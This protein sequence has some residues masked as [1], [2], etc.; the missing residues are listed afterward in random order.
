PMSK[1]KSNRV[2]LHRILKAPVERVFRAFSDPD[3]M[4]YWLPPF[5]FL[6]KVLEQDFKVGG[7]Y[8]MAFINFTDNASH[9]FGGKYVEI[10][11]GEVISYTDSFDDPN[12]PGEMMTTVRFRE[13][14][15]GTE[16]HIVQEGLPDAIPAEMC[17]L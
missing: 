14:S 4:N 11:P 8:R 6:G 1:S 3:A 13:V 12:M 16:I 5:G 15:C 7:K 10:R 9:S 17:Y 2:E